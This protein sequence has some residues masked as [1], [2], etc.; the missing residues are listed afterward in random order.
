VDL[1]R[2]EIR[3]ILPREKN[4]TSE[5]KEGPREYAHW[6]GMHQNPGRL[7][8]RSRLHQRSVLIIRQYTSRSSW[9]LGPTRAVQKHLQ[10]TK[11]PVIIHSL[12]QTQNNKCGK[13]VRW[14]GLSGQ[15]HDSDRLMNCSTVVFLTPPRHGKKNGLPTIFYSF[16][17]L[18]SLPLSFRWQ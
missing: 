14:T 16:P 15:V 5:K 2:E 4:S 10:L 13:T 17:S 12:V 18:H 8:R 11:V 7:H 1:R 6:S 9:R 3:L